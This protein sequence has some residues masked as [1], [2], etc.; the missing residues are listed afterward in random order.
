MNCELYINS[1]PKG[2]RIA[3]M[4]NKRLVEYHVENNA[5]S[6]TVG[7]IFLGNVTKLV[8]GLNAAFVDVGYEKDAF[9]HYHD[10]GPQ[11]K[12]L[13]KYVKMVQNGD[14][15]LG[16]K[17][18]GFKG[19][20][21]IDKFGKIGGVLSRSQNI[22]VQVVKEPISTK[23]PRLSCE[24]SIAGRY[25][26]LVPFS[27]SV[28]VSKKIADKD[29]RQRL[30]RLIQSIKPENFGVIIRT[31]AQG[32]EVAELDKDLKSLLKK[33]EDGFNT[34]RTARPKDKIIG[35]MNRAS[36]I[37]RDLL[38]EGF[39][40]IV[41]D[42]KDIYEEIKTYIKTIAPDK[43]K[44]L[45]LYTGKQKLFEEYGIEKQIKASFGKTV[46]LTNGG[47]LI[48]EH[49][50]ALHVIDVNS[51]NKTSADGDQEDTALAV[52]L[53]ACTEV[54]R[55]LKLRDLGGIIV[56]DFIDMKNPENR[57]FLFAKMKEEMASD[58]SKFTV[59]PLSKFGLM[60][61]TRQR[62]RPQLDISNLE[63]C[64][65][66]NGSGTIQSAINIPDTIEQHIDYLFTKQNESKVLINLHPLLY[67]H[68]TKG[69]IS[70]RLK[71]Y[72]KYKKWVEL[73]KDSALGITEYT[74]INGQ[75][76]EI[77]LK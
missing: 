2:D 39:D 67:D 15:S 19:E 28:N 49:T 33:W 17:L 20:Q 76:E 52:N 66:C 61:I 70:K 72:F 41:V 48:I 36:S 8:Q 26:V 6:F 38:N 32:K 63:T 3:L 18:Q 55:Q 43:E 23:G 75:G 57:N 71:W 42:N 1:T 10:L 5:N 31:V 13:N 73:Y 16:Y 68:F 62:V 30:S 47:Y 27:T 50:E 34:L 29:E 53:D 7:D 69:L 22:L 11:I 14:K 35:E 59:L 21:D 12:S 51:G 58:R 46:S 77:E 4:N 65:T 25:L 40:A 44:I 56:V 24:V 74:F 64:P 45:K 60:Q 37:L 9:L 54:A